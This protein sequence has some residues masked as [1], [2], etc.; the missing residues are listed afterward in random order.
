VQQVLSSSN[1]TTTFLDSIGRNS[2]S[3][4]NSYA[5]GLKHFD[6]F[7][8]TNVAL[9]ADTIIPQLLNQEVN[10]Y[11]LLNEFVSYLTKL[12]ITIPSM[13]MYVAAVRS[14]LEFQDIDISISKFKR[15]VK[16]QKHY[17]E[18]ELPLEISDIRNLLIQCRNERL[19]TYLLVIASSGMRAKEACSLR[20]QDVDFTISP[21]RITTR[22]EFSKTRRSRTIYISNEA[23]DHLKRFLNGRNYDIK[24]QDLIFSMQD[25][26]KNPY[27]IYN[28]LLQQFHKLLKKA[29]MNTRKEN[30]RRRKITIHSFRRTVFSII[31]DQVGSEYANWYLGHDHS[32]YWTKKEQERRQIY[33]TKC[34][35][36][37]T[38]L[39]YS[40]FET[41]GKHI[42]AKLSEKEQEIQL[43]RQRDT[44][45]TDAISSL[46]DQ[47]IQIM[48]EIEL[49]KQGE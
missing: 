19:Y 41:R 37:L 26:T 29:G 13:K 14:Y 34:M 5:S 9:D 31:N 40:L 23:T 44:I 12:D 32:E 30:S 45:N 11:E 48:K 24:P 38:V 47:L 8:Q 42:E 33:A 15:R 35:P 28:R 27:T 49:L 36:Y 25:K 22:K 43:L 3:T 2:K 39:D 16:M 1:R 10:V 46:S 20:L 7:L 18:D 21:T 6:R 4:Q 17:R